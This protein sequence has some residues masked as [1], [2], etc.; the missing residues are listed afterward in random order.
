MALA[1]VVVLAACGRDDAAA[2]GE[3]AQALQIYEVPPAQL[4]S[5]HRALREVLE[6]N[7]T[8]SVSSSDGKLVV[9]APASTQASIGSAIESLS[10]L[11]ADAGP[12]NDVPIRLRFWLL[13][14]S[15][16]ENPADPRLE[17]LKPALDAA[18]RGL[19]LHGYSLQ[20]F[21]EVLTTPGKSF[22]T[23]TS[24]LI[25]R[26]GANLSGAGVT[27]DITMDMKQHDAF[28]DAKIET[29]ALLEPGQF[30]VLGT[31]AAADGS[32]RLI[33][34]QAQLAADEI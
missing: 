31:S 3:E 20:G 4:Q 12:A 19:G 13:Q 9:L 14:G 10:Q 22:T 6:V 7:K 27:L 26:G 11:P 15:A 1:A 17:P 25:A 29:G 23:E 33:V 18:S 34:A 30:L 16:E 2:P 28:W 32:M 21:T 5:V 8:G 24:N